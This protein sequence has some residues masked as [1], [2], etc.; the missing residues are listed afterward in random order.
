MNFRYLTAL[1]MMAAL[2]AASCTR[3][4]ITDGKDGVQDLFL[5]ASSPDDVSVNP[6]GTKTSM[7]PNGDC[8]SVLWSED[9]VISVNGVESSAIAVEEGNAKKGG[10]RSQGC[11][12]AMLCG[13]SGFLRFGLFRRGGE[14]LFR[15]II[16]CK[17]HIGKDI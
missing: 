15:H 17:L 2:L 12:S 7:V 4:E 10:I 16:W 6:F 1:G 11:G 3:D 13:L 8:Y 5:T 14:S 9:D